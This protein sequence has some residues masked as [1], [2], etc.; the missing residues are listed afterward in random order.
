MASSSENAGAPTKEPQVSAP[1]P[2][3]SEEASGEEAEEPQTLERAQELFDQGSKAIEEDDFVEAVDCLSRALEIRFWLPPVPYTRSSLSPHR[4]RSRVLVEAPQHCADKF[5]RLLPTRTAHYG[6]LA[7][8]CASTYYKYGVALLYK[9]KEESDPLGSVPKSAP[10]EE[11]VKSTTGKNYGESSKASGSN[12]EDAASSEKV[13]AE[14]GQNSN[15][16]DQEDGNDEDVDGDDEKAG[17]EDDSDLD[18]S[19]KMLDIARVIVEKSPDNILL[20]VKIFSALGE[21]SLEREEIDTSLS[22]YFKALAIL[23]QLGEPDHRL[24]VEVNFRICLVYELVCKNEDALPYCAKAISSCKSR[25][26]RLKNSKDVLLAGK[27]DNASVAEGRSEKSL[28]D[29]IESLTGILSDLEQKVAMR[30]ANAQKDANA[31]PRAAS[32]ASSQ[33]ATSS[34]GF[35]FLNY[36]YSSN[37][38]KHRKYC[39]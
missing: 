7:P 38:W 15:G 8:E 23:E 24:I 31:M 25:I 34:N 17:D 20:K 14:K 22:D 2:N 10:K 19:W 1:P 16:K 5:M 36:V 28:A 35:R 33:M 11:S 26:E 6:E 30:A 32:F 37:N 3:P 9:Y 12:V 27:D 39:N 18:L 4:V 29:E 13:D 21:V